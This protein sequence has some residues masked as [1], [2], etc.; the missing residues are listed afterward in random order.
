MEERFEVQ[1]LALKQDDTNKA[2]KFLQLI[3]RNY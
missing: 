2:K 3:K 1:D